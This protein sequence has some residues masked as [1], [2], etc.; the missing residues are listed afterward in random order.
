M[1]KQVIG[2]YNSEEE[3]ILAVNR[4]ERDGFEAQDL[5]IVTNRRGN[6]EALE[7]QTNI[8]VENGT[9]SSKED[10]SFWESI[11]RL[12]TDEEDTNSVNPTDQLINLG[13]TE[14]DAAVYREDLAA[15]GILL[16]SD[17]NPALETPFDEVAATLTD[18]EPDVVDRE[19]IKRRE[20][21]LLINKN[22][23]QTGEVQVDKN[24]VEEK[25]NI[26]IPLEKDEVHV[27]RRPVLDYDDSTEPI[28]DNESI[29]IPIVEEEVE[30][31]KKPVVK[32][33]IVI[34]KSKTY[35]TKHV[36]DTVKKEEVDIKSEDMLERDKQNRGSLNNDS[37]K[38]F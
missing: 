20:E 24:V 17:R 7:R 12:F 26:E 18:T 16:L 21:E 31:R 35:D 3:A 6:T 2:S 32:E 10:E 38:L 15:G 33:E 14:E 9:A 28:E 11:K 25:Q 23:V 13:L 27:K 37:D 8:N 22:K 29:R 1:V 34:D 19:K 30:V 4:L 5:T 36:A